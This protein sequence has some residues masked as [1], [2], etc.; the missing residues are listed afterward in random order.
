VKVT[1]PGYEAVY[2]IEVSRVSKEHAASSSGYFTAM[3]IEE[4]HFSETSVFLYQ[5]TRRHNPGDSYFQ[6]N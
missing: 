6:K 4:T 1:L 2:M 5:S 3:K